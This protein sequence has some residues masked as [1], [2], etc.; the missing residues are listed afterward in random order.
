MS[1]RDALLAEFDQEMAVT[2]RLLERVPENAFGWKPH[3]ASFSLG[4]L[5]THVAQLP[6]WGRQIL[7]QE[8]YD[9]GASTGRATP[10]DTLADVLTTFD[11]HVQ[12]VRRALTSKADAELQAP[13]SLKRGAHTVLTMPRISAVRRFMM[14]HV[15]HHRGQL[16]VYLRLQG[17]PLPPIY[18]PS[19]DEPA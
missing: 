1:V 12:E 9:I 13:W 14:H 19:A 4:G 15:I 3:E 10:K 7:D 11:A 17:V 2:R 6:H 8:F 5:A 16:T 18:G